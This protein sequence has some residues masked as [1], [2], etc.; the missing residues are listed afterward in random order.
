[1]AKNPAWRL[2]ITSELSYPELQIIRLLIAE[3]LTEKGI[4]M[5]FLHRSNRLLTPEF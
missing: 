2:S 5:I 3:G 4:H 1:V